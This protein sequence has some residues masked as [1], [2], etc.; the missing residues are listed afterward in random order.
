MMVFLI[1]ERRTIMS[2]KW[3]SE[4][5]GV[6]GCN[7]VFGGAF[8]CTWHTS[9]FGV[10]IFFWL[11]IFLIFAYVYLS[12][13]LQKC[14]MSLPNWGHQKKLLLSSYI[15]TMP[16]CPSWSLSSTL[17]CNLIE[18]M[19]PH[20]IHLFFTESS[21]RT[22]CVVWFQFVILGFVSLSI[23]VKSKTFD[24]VRSRCVSR[25]T[26]LALTGRLSLWQ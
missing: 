8:W 23:K 9:V 2:H 26:S 4:V 19:T 14:S 24:R 17:F 12:I 25:F 20:I 13:F 1:S 18:I 6:Q 7:D 5:E 10:G 22:T 21:F 3:T 15:F 11:R 16:K